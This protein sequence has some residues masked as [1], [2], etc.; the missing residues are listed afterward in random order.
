M[1]T[2]KEICAKL[3]EGYDDL[4]TGK[5]QDAV[6]PFKAFRKKHRAMDIHRRLL[7]DNIH[8]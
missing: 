5:T 8:I 4:Q 1:T 3:Q 7:E 6:S 2:V